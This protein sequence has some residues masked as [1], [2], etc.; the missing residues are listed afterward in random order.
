MSAL[1]TE[2]EPTV[3]LLYVDPTFVGSPAIHC[4][5]YVL[6]AHSYGLSLQRTP[7]VMPIVPHS[8]G[9]SGMS[10]KIHGKLQG[11]FSDG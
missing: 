9:G 3:R 6:Q 10:L 5:T 2:G 7:H 4:T 8:D 11:Q 1:A